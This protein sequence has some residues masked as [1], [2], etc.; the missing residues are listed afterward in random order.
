MTNYNNPTPRAD[1]R[2]DRGGGLEYLPSAMPTHLKDRY[3]QSAR[4][5]N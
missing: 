2:D 4:G 5:G 3:P 1:Q